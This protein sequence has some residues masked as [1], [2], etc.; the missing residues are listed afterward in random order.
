MSCIGVSVLAQC[1]GASYS[2]AF[3]CLS[4]SDIIPMFMCGY[5][6]LPM[7]G[8]GAFP[9]K[10]SLSANGLDFASAEAIILSF[11]LYF[12]LFRIIY[13]AEFSDYKFSSL[14]TVGSSSG[15]LMNCEQVFLL[16]Q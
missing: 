13:F 7:N 10:P 2:H 8:V 4:V 12:T 16:S 5:P 15:P 14:V 3:S 1:F 11:C 6:I 9:E